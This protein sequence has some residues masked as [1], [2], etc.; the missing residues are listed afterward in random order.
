M[1][2]NPT[3]SLG[4]AVVLLMESAGESAV[5]DST[6]GRPIAERWCAECHV[7]TPGQS[8]L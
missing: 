7:V 8:S 5:A 3:A 1:T 4:V 2:V 6:N